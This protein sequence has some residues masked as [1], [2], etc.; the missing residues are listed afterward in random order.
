MLAV[1]F[2]SA[3]VAAFAQASMTGVIKDS[4]GAVLPGVTVEASSPTLIEKVR[5]VITDST[6][7][8]RIVDLRPGTYAL[9]ASLTGFSTF[10]REGIELTGSITVTVPIEMRVGALQETITVTG[11]SPVVDVQSV[12]RQVSIDNTTLNEIPSARG[13]GPLVLL[14][15]AIITGG[16]S[17]TQVAP[18]MVVFG[19]AG[20]RGSEGRVQVDGLAI[21]AAIGG[22][23][24]SSYVADTS[25]AQEVTFTNQGGLGAVSYTHLTLPTI[26]SV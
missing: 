20:G 9:T 23:G 11:E 4:S 6:G 16:P 15:P 25:N 17:N 1:W 10:R 13:Y 2:V 5:S 26:Y 14:Q 3:P 24:S 12:R 19:A 7:Q 21:G 22:S 18:G 8:Y